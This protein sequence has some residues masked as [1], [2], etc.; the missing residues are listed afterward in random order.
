MVMGKDMDSLLTVFVDVEEE[1]L[2]RTNLCPHADF[3]ALA[4]NAEAE[5]YINDDI[6]TDHIFCNKAA[7]TA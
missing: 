4:A 7:R 3:F 5:R 1:E 6:A 2:K